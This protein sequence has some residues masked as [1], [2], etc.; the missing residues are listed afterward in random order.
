MP[1]ARFP[2]ADGWDLH[3]NN[4]PAEAWLGVTGPQGQLAAFDCR[5]DSVRYEVLQQL[6]LDLIGA[7]A[8]KPGAEPK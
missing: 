3:V 4:T 5:F 8:A 1:S 7:A 6:L 2:L